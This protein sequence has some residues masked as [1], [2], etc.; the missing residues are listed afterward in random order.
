MSAARAC[1][2]IAGLDPLVRHLLQRAAA[3]PEPEDT[4][5]LAAALDHPIKL[6]WDR[7]RLAQRGEEIRLERTM[8]IGKLADEVLL[9]QDRRAR[10][11]DPEPHLQIR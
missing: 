2:C 9:A 11:F 5:A 8:R 7:K 4:D 6:R 3:V 10:F 1:R